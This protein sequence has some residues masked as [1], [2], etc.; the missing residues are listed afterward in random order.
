MTIEL[1]PESI[2]HP[3]PTEIVDRRP[4]APSASET[5]ARFFGQIIGDRYRIERL[6]ARGGM[7]HVYGGTELDVDRPVAVKILAVG[8]RGRDDRFR[9]RF[10][11]EASIASRLQ[12]PNVVTIYDYGETGTGD[13]FIAMERVP[14]RNLGEVLEDEKRLPV[15][16]ALNIAIQIAR[17]L[18]KAHREGAVHRDLKPDNIMVQPD[19]DGLDFVKILD[20]GL[21]KLF[22][23]EMAESEDEELQPITHVGTMM[24]TPAYMAPEQAVGEAVDGRAD[25]YALGA[26]L[27]E[28]IAGRVPFQAPGVVE[29]V[30]MHLVKPPPRLT[31]LVACPID[32]TMIVDR[33]L[34]KSPLD[35][36]QTVDELLAHLKAAWRLLTDESFG[37]DPTFVIPD[38]VPRESLARSTLERAARPANKLEKRCSWLGW[39]TGKGPKSNF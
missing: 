24:G 38:L 14:G 22:V 26:M 15:I 34:R 30:N 3:L 37:T 23:P 32:V 5:T 8:D 9:R 18:R 11:R 13:L 2:R 16:R 1:S 20:F 29:L 39:I 7:G 36:Y 35:R 19:E 10:H 21:V 31:E 28:M 27:F 4:S 33:C 6:I 25:I 12:H 17:G